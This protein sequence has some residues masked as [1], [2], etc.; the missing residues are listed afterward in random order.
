M[1]PGHTQADEA[2]VQFERAL[3]RLILIRG[4]GRDDGGAP[5]PLLAVRYSAECSSASSS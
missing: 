1:N 3:S 4:P 2:D 5:A